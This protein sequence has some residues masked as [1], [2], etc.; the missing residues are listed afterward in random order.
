MIDIKCTNCGKKLG[1][2]D[3]KDGHVLIKC[4]CGTINSFAA[5]PG[6]K[7]V[8]NADSFTDRLKFEKKFELPPNEKRERLGLIK[9]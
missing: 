5:L 9:K 6:D 2:A 8:D 1:E 3:I 4:K 7:K